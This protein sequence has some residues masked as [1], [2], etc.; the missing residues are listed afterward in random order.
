M[1]KLNI[2]TAMFL[3]MG[4]LFGTQAMAQG[5]IDLNGV[6]SAQKCANVTEDGFTATFSFSGIQANEVS[7]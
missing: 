7:T 2:I 6:K 5:R 1:K 3:L 4:M